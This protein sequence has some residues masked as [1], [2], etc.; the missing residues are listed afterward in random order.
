MSFGKNILSE[1]INPCPFWDG[2]KRNNI[3]INSELVKLPDNLQIS[4]TEYYSLTKEKQLKWEDSIK[5][6]II[7]YEFKSIIKQYYWKFKTFLKL[8]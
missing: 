5:A 1:N 7:I 4:L 3:Y 6:F 2:I 8:E